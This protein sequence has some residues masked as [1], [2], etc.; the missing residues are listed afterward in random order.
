MN[1]IKMTNCQKKHINVIQWNKY[2]ETSS[3]ND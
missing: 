3:K 2:T 1:L